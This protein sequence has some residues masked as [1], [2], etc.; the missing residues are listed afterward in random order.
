[1]SELKISQSL[2]LPCGAIIKNRI[3][4]SAMSENMASH[5]HLPTKNFETVYETWANGGSGLLI[6]G[7]VMI[8][9]RYLGEPNNVVIERGFEGLTEL[10]KWSYAGKKNNTHIWMQINHPGKQAPKFLCR[11]PVAPSAIPFKSGL[12]RVFNP[13]RALLE[14]EIYEIIERYVFAAKMAKE[15]G[16]T[17]VQIHGAH[18]YLVSQFLSPLHNTRTDQWGGSITHRMR[19]VMLIY[20]SLRKALGP[21]FPISIKLNSSDFQNGGFSEMDSLIVAQEL[22]DAGMDLIEISGGTYESPEMMGIKSN[23]KKEST[24]K[25]EAYFLEFSNRI[26]NAIKTPVML[27][28]GFR[29]LSGMEQTLESNS[30][31]VIGMGRSIVL[32]PNFANELL[33]G[34]NVES[35]VH[36]L[37]T[38]N[39]TLDKVFPLEIIWY[40]HQIHKLGHGIPPNPNQNV[41]L[42]LINSVM[43][44]GLQSLFRVRSK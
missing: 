4:K 42:T 40:T 34:K 25:R 11:E 28:G 44:M 36:P 8:D 13:P 26:R 16:F 19:F 10:T 1:M 41:L 7:N 20:T 29:T 5:N 39:K 22:S 24:L 21:D 31:D 32:N 9:T 38:G 12:A 17:G 23:Y 6:S 15:A 2:T 18:G 3:A 27:T 43:S 37:S 14:D 35:K 30:C 33:T